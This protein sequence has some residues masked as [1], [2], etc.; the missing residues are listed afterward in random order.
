MKR[1]PDIIIAAGLVG[2]AIALGAGFRW[3]GTACILVALIVGWKRN[4]CMMALEDLVTIRKVGPDC[5]ADALDVGESGDTG[6][7][8]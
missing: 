4:W 8:D 3:V 2:C 1:I 5:E 6:D 7:D